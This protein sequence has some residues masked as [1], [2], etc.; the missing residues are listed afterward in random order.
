MKTI[1]AV[2]PFLAII[3]L[4]AFVEWLENESNKLNET[5]DRVNGWRERVINFFMN[6]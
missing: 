6:E 3:A 4:A 5:T 2:L 1:F